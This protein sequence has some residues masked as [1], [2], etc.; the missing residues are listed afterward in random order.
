M[1]M[2]LILNSILLAHAIQIHM[3]E[4]TGINKYL[5]KEMRKSIEKLIG[6]RLLLI[7]MKPILGY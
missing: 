4:L 1:R 7:S 2:K 6:P 3:Q 5:N